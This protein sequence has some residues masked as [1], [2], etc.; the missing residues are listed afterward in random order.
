MLR[1]LK[2]Q[3]N[4]TI[5]SKLKETRLTTFISEFLSNSGHFLI[6]KNLSDVA[7]YGWQKY[8]TDPTEYLLAQTCNQDIFKPGLNAI[9]IV[10]QPGLTAT[11]PE[12]FATNLQS[13]V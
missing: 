13:S 4:N 6:L 5:E 3:S 11:E 9:I 8:I 12:L 2:H 1:L 10:L 7:L